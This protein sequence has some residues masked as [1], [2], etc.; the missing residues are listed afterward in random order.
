MKSLAIVTL[1]LRFFEK[2]CQ[3]MLPGFLMK[4][5]PSEMSLRPKVAFTTSWRNLAFTWPMPA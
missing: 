5:V 1:P 3:R 4:S 2:Y